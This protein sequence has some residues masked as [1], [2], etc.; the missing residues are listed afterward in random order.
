M[1]EHER[2][3]RREA[4]RD[5][6]GDGVAE[7]HAGIQAGSGARKSAVSG[8]LAA[9]AQTTLEHLVGSVDGLARARSPF[10]TPSR[11]RCSG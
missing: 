9:E 5:V 6:A 11:G 10:T 7:L 4:L 2:P 1:P 3:I 8:R